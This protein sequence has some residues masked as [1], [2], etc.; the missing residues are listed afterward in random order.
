MSITSTTA[1]PST[2]RQD[3]EFCQ[4]RSCAFDIETTGLKVERE[5]I[6]EIGAVV[7]HNGE[8]AE[9]FQTFVNPEPPPDA[10]DRGPDGHHG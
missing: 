1:S 4:T 5:A 2:V 9:R 6:T 10:G 8:V 3:A 7:L